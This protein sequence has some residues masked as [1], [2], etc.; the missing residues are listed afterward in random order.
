MHTRRAFFLCTVMVLLLIA[1][2]LVAAAQA[3]DATEEPTVPPEIAPTLPPLP[4]ETPVVLPTFIPTSEPTTLPQPTLTETPTVEATPEATAP[5]ETTL[6]ETPVIT[7]EALPTLLPAVTEM[8]LSPDT[9][10][11]PAA[12]SAPLAVPA[13]ICD[14]NAAIQKVAL[15]SNEE[16]S[17]VELSADGRYVVLSKYNRTDRYGPIYVIVLDFFFYDRLNCQTTALPDYP[18]DL[19]LAYFPGRTTADG[20]YVVGRVNTGRTFFSEEPIRFIHDIYVHDRQIGQTTIISVPVNGGLSDDTSEGAVI[21]A[22]GRFV[23]YQ[24]QARN[25]VAD[26]GQVCSGDQGDPPIYC[27]VILVYDRQTGQTTRILQSDGPWGGTRYKD[28]NFVQLEGLSANGQRAAY[29]Y[30]SPECYFFCALGRIY[31]LPAG[32]ITEL[33]VNLDGDGM[34][35]KFGSLK[36]SGDGRYLAYDYNPGSGDPQSITQVIVYDSQT[37]QYEY[38]SAAPNRVSGNA[39][40]VTPAIS[41]DGRYI[42]FNSNASNLVSGDTNDTADVFVYDRQTHRNVRISV[43]ASGAQGNGPSGAVYSHAVTISGDGQLAAFESE[44]SNL[45]EGDTNGIKDVFL[46][47]VVFPALPPPQPPVL[48]APTSG[49]LTNSTTLTFSWN[50]APNAEQY[51]LLID[52]DR[53]F[54]SPAEAALV[55]GLSYTSTSLF[56]HQLYW[57]VDAL[58]SSGS[59]R[60]ASWYFTVDTT[61][62]AAPVLRSPANS[63]VVTMARPAFSWLAVPTATRYRLEIDRH[64]AFTDAVSRTE[65]DMLATAPVTL[66]QNYYF[67]R[68]QARDAA[69][70]WGPYSEARQFQFIILRSPA[71]NT[72]TGTQRPTFLWYAY[73]GARSYQIQVDDSMTFDSPIISQIVSN[74]QTGFAPTAALPYGMYFWRVNV[75]LGGGFVTSP[76]FWTVTVKLPGL[77]APVLTS[78]ASGAVGS[79]PVTLI[80]SAVSGGETYE[81]LIDDDPNF[82][83]PGGMRFFG[84]SA[85]ANLPPGRYYWKVRAWNAANQPG[86]WSVTRSFTVGS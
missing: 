20:R 30:E 84:L 23:V 72:D 59:A 80:W 56:D 62:P 74:R 14:P 83:T 64:P 21:S 38:A 34:S 31:D 65:T 79:S 3:E 40:S 18:K 86:G 39:S 17:L 8:S 9:G 4:T 76:V 10:E 24:T 13:A 57:R 33:P 32:T 55:T 73:P 7:L 52:D 25:L 69:G 51:R 45:V 77:N 68:V 1:V 66:T 16:V 82:Y 54:S 22:D 42:A 12:D 6:T 15:P 5:P 28:N 41:L 48:I 50:T 78:P 58:N 37:G 49:T 11:L 2:P 81:Y 47:K 35:E 27:P 75:D 43:S 71:H 63:S 53:D 61:P 36:I 67:W 26:P 19:P 85:P 60:S 29:L 70:N 46:A 44:A